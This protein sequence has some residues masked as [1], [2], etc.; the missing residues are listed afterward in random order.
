MKINKN[1]YQNMEPWQLNQ[2]LLYLCIKGDLEIV[3]YLLNSSELKEYA[4]IHNKDTD[5]DNP[6]IWASEKEN[7]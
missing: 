5:G 1:I 2:E 6:L 7:L 4:D 3:K